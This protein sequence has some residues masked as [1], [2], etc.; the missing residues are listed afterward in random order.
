MATVATTTADLVPAPGLP[1][2]AKAWAG[3]AVGL[4]TSIIAALLM[5][6]PADGGFGDLTVTQWL[7]V[8]LAV[9]SGPAVGA[10]VGR[11]P[12][13]LQPV[14]VVDAPPGGDTPLNGRHAA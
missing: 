3:A 10:I 4:A 12:N 11:V 2:Y 7:G 14:T 13:A 1:G 5:V 9:L 8:G 6:L